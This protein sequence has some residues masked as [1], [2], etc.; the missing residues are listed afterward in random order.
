MLFVAIQGLRLQCA[1][2]ATLQCLISTQKRT[3]VHEITE[4]AQ[5]RKGRFL[6]EPK[7]AEPVPGQSGS[8]V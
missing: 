8:L 7:R 6:A 3:R 1:L 5:E 2:P 4:P